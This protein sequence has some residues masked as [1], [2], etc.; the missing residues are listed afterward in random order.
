MATAKSALPII[1]TL[2]M[3]F[4]TEALPETDDGTI[5]LRALDGPRLD[6][7]VAG[8]TVLAVG[9][10]IGA[11][12]ETAE[13]V[14]T[15]VNKYPLPLVLD[16]D[17]LNAFAGRM[18]SLR[19]DVRPAGTTVFTPHPGEMARLTG[20]TIAEIQAQRVAVA[21]EF[22]QRFGV[23]LV[24]K[25]FRTLIASPDGQVEV[26]PTGNPGM[27]KGGT[28]DVLTGL[29]A[30]LLAQFPAHPVGE[31]AT[32]AVYL[33]GMAGDL[34]AGELGQHSMLA[35]DLLEKIPQAY[36]ELTIVD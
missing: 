28:G 6:K 7:L 34:A 9:P 27:A 35:G 24:L 33:H 13:L 18:E 23:T 10:G 30:G 5:S 14:R 26:N 16:A 36:K 31:V 11:H 17:G 2:G 20:K 1:S 21:R 29:M 8:K 32:A 3:E 12:P 4:M 25:G 15:I 22:S 19:Q